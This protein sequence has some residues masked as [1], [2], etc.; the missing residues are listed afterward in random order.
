MLLGNL[1]FK[2]ISM[3]MV[4]NIVAFVPRDVEIDGYL[5]EYVVIGSIYN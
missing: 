4:R 3:K 5:N 1:D 2:I